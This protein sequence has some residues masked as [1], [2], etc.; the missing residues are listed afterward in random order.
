MFR[1]AKTGTVWVVTLIVRGLQ[2][3][4]SPVINPPGFILLFIKKSYTPFFD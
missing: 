4:N 2:A 3:N 1:L